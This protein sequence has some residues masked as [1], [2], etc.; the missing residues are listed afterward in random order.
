[1]FKNEWYKKFN[2]EKA[3]IFNFGLII[4]ALYTETT[5]L[6]AEIYN[7][8]KCCLTEKF[9]KYLKLFTQFQ[10]NSKNS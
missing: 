9:D 8:E 10:L 5:P 2:N 3:T 1:M 4:I 6:E 7:Y